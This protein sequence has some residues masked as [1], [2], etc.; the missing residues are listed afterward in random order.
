[1]VRMNEERLHDIISA[2]PTR[3]VAVIG[4]FCVD[5]Y[6]EIDPSISDRSNETGLPIHQV[7]GVR[8]EPGG[9]ANVLNNLAALGVGSVLP[10]GFLGL[11]GEGFELGRI[12]D[13]LGFERD[14]LQILPDRHTPVFTKPV[15][16]RPDGAPEE[17]N[18]FDIFPREPL[19][20]EQEAT[21]LEHL[22]AAFE[23]ADALIVADYGEAGKEGVVT[24]RV[25]ERVAELARTQREKPVIADSRLHIDRFRQ[26]IIKPNNFEAM[27]FLAGERASPPTLT[28]LAEVGERAAERNRQPVLITLGPEGALLCAPGRALKIPVY[29]SEREGETDIVGAGDAVLAA[30]A[31]TLGAGAGVDEAV[32]IGMLVASITI[33]EIGRC[34]SADPDQ[35]HRRFREYAREF[36]DVVGD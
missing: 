26:V 17:L 28:R 12:F 3:T 35:V 10:V 34:G 2:L 22:G 29:P 15:V 16:I 25:R 11:D 1:M 21:L 24:A 14:G 36:P 8:A 33:Q 18:R 31:A 13:R 7:V 32:L 27:E 23:A 9:G 20:E 30:V 5:R 6:F 19:S 4:D